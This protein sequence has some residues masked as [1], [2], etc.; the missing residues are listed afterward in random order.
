M[1]NRFPVSIKGV[2]TIAG[3][4]VLLK[5][6]RGEWELPGGRIEAG[7]SPELCVLREIEEELGIQAEVTGI[8]DAWLFEVLP[9]KHVF[10]TTYACTTKVQAAE[11]LQISHE[12]KEVG[13]FSLEAALGL[14]MPVGY[15]RSLTNYSAQK[16]FE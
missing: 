16:Q 7:E 4:F 11:T 13:L 9:G 5:N 12:H 10:I 8:L 1:N 14:N 2:V 15:K 6:E 3:K